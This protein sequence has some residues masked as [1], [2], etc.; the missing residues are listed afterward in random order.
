M[1]RCL[2]SSVVVLSLTACATGVPASASWPDA[3]TLAQRLPAYDYVLLGEVHDHATGHQWRYE[4]LAQAVAQGWRPVIAMEQFDLEQTQALMQ[5]Q[6]SCGKDAD[7]VIA[8]AAPPK[9]AWNW[10]YY[11]PVIA[12]A[13]DYDLPLV[14]ANLSRQQAGQVL[15]QGVDAVFDPAQQQALGLDGDLPQA[16][17]PQHVN[18]FSEL[19]GGGATPAEVEPFAWA[20]MARDAVMAQRLRSAPTRPVVLIAGNGHVR[21][22]VGVVPWLDVAPAQ[23]LSV[24][25]VTDTPLAQQYDIAVRLPAARD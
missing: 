17:L 2:L 1:I 19:H 15:R 6:A 5:A 22:D 20:Q 25:F 13:L 8:R 23:V 7:C 11:R 16:L 14:A 18:I 24:G 9:N 3:P 12:L 10:A 4:A 21:R